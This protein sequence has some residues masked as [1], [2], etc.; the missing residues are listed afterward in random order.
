VCHA[1]DTA[2]EKD[3]VDLENENPALAKIQKL[4]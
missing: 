1:M 2:A 4:P 3:E